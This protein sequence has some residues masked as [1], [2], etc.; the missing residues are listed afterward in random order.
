MNGKIFKE[1]SV[2]PRSEQSAD[3]REQS[4]DNKA[5]VDLLN[6]ALATELVC[7]LRYKS[8]R[9][10][11]KG[12]FGP[13]MGRMFWEHADEEMD[14]ANWIAERI[15]QLGGVPNYS[16]VHLS[17]RAHS[18]YVESSDLF[19]MVRENAR[20][21][22]VAIAFYR[23]MIVQMGNTDSTTRRMI[24]KILATE[25]E[26]ADELGAV[27]APSAGLDSKRTFSDD[28]S[29]FAESGLLQGAA[30]RNYDPKQNYPTEKI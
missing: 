18:A 2:K 30:Y 27:L 17:E 1:S 9:F 20:A 26:H 10:A 16:P 19:E 7:V 21:E 4:G 11:A 15:S 8:H 13:E 22:Q 5:T 25:E 14:H 28:A 12:P 23:A 6:A 29:K 24:E 3:S